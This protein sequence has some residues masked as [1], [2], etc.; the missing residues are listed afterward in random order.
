[1]SFGSIAY[2][3]CGVILAIAAVVL[4]ILGQRGNRR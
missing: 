1:M 3:S 4:I 2:V